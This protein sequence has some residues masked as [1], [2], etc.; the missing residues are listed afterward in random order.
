MSYKTVNNLVIFFF[1]LK[2]LHNQISKIS[3]SLSVVTQFQQNKIKREWKEIQLYS[4][5]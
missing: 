3:C 5:F 2:G 4:Q 1:F